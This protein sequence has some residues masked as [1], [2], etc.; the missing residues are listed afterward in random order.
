LGAAVVEDVAS[1]LEE[2]EEMVDGA[3]GFGLRVIWM[4]VDGEN[5]DMADGPVGGSLHF[6]VNVA[7]WIGESVCSLSRAYVSKNDDSP[8]LYCA[9]RP[10]RRR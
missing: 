4:C 8:Y 7:V 3:I 1:G 9:R 5:E 2:N 10:S 6:E